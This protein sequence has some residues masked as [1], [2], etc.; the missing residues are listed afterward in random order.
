MI[1]LTRSGALFFC[2][3]LF[4][5]GG[6]GTSSGSTT[7]TGSSSGAATTS[8][9]GSESTSS[10]SGSAPSSGTDTASSGGGGPV[11]P[12][13]SGP[14]PC[15]EFVPGGTNNPAI[16]GMPESQLIVQAAADLVGAAE[17]D[18]GDLAAACEA[19][20]VNLGASAASQAQANAASDPRAKANA[21]C[22]LA[23][24]HLDISKAKAG[25]FMDVEMGS[26]SYCTSSTFDGAACKASCA[27]ARCN[28]ACDVRVIAATS[29][30]APTVD[31][32]SGAAS[33]PTEA[34]KLEA[35]LEAHLPP[36]LV[37]DEKCELGSKVVGSFYG[38]VNGVS[39]IKAACIPTVKAATGNASDNVLAC[40]TNASSIVNRMR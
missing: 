22:A 1:F 14:P 19:I 7:G 37:L 35:T 36:I 26:T 8:S 27:S 3:L 6:G 21:W 10:S 2:T 12:G 4:G 25:G 38:T 34:A 18:I 29:C 15:P 28:E 40:L 13:S 31:V 39:D 33:D 11:A 23:G 5:C 16:G 32:T 17:Q 9:G 20:A 30:A 24:K